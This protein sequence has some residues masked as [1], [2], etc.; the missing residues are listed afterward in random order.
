MALLLG[1][2]VATLS[3]MAGWTHATGAAVRG[4]SVASGGTVVAGTDA[5]VVA[6]RASD[7]ARLWAHALPPRAAAKFTILAHGGAAFALSTDGA[8]SALELSGGAQRWRHQAGARASVGGAVYGGG[9]AGGRL[10]FGTDD[11]ALHALYAVDGSAQ[12]RYETGGGAMATPALSAS[13]ALV[14]APAALDGGGGALHAVFAA[15]G[16]KAW[17]RAWAGGAPALAGAAAFSKPAVAGGA[18][19]HAEHGRL[20]VGT[21]EGRLEKLDPADGRTLCSLETGGGAFVAPP[22]LWLHPDGAALSVFGALADGS[23]RAFDGA[24]CAQRWSYGAGGQSRLA[25]AAAVHAAHPGGAAVLVGSSAAAPTTAS[26][27]ATRLAGSAAAEAGRQVAA[28]IS[29]DGA[30]VYMAQSDQELANAPPQRSAALP[31]SLGSYVHALDAV[32]GALRWRKRLGG[33]VESEVGVD[34][35]G[36]NV[37]VG[38]SDGS[39]YAIAPPASQ[40]TGWVAGVLTAACDLS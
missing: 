39:L 34:G 35:A 2:A 38:C 3:S 1:L 21:G 28:A 5:G 22:T 16:T 26:S 37:L 6:V 24:T 27:A 23:V 40:C 4:G 15:N 30:R 13:G 32:S 8:M 33:A 17:A 7:G 36:G 11:G 19:A 20:F 31:P 29:P 25:A 10:Y 18:A 12:W 14:L 9:T